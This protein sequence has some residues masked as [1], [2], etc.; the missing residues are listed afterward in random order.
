MPVCPQLILISWAAPAG[1]IGLTI[2]DD[3]DA[4]ALQQ[5]LRADSS[6]QLLGFD[7][8]LTVPATGEAPHGLGFTG[9]PMFCALWSFL[10]LPAIMLPM[11]HSPKGLPLGLQLVAPYRQDGGLLHTARW[12]EQTLANRGASAP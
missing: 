2:Q 8:V 1:E 4:L 7:A 11:G 12:V 5:Q 9:D 10:G 3:L 6:A